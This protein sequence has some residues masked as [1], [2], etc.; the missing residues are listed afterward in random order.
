MISFPRLL[1]LMVGVQ[2]LIWYKLAGESDVVIIYPLR[3]SVVM[4]ACAD[5]ARTDISVCS[6]HVILWQLYS[7]R[8]TTGYMSGS[9]TFTR[10]CQ[11]ITQ[12]IKHK[13][14]MRLATRRLDHGDVAKACARVTLTHI[15][16]GYPFRLPRTRWHRPTLILAWYVARATHLTSR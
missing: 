9:V 2:S 5:K 1:S 15:W 11:S 12:S 16:K 4:E 7:C 13:P 3:L 6:S 10:L 14:C 8:L